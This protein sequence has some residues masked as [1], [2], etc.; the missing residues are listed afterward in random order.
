MTTPKLLVPDVSEWQ[1]TIDWSALV[2]GG[3]PAA[4]IRVYSGSRADTQFARN[5][6]EAHA[7]GIKALGLY[8][9][10]LPGDIEEQAAA[11]VSLVGTLRPGEWPIVDYEAA[12]LTPEE[13]L[14][15]IAHVSKAL[16]GSVPWLYASEYVFRSEHL[17]QV[18]PSTRTW[19]AAWGPT[20][21]SEAHE[22][23]QY[24][25]H[26]SGVPGI[27]GSV[28]CSTF[29][30]NVDQLVAA[31]SPKAPAP[32]PGPTSHPRFP[33]PAG[34]KP[35]GTSPS[36]R[37]LQQALKRTEWMDEN[38]PESDHYGPLTEKGV[39]GFNRKHGLNSSGKSWDP[40]IG[41]QGWA[42]LMTL[43]YGRD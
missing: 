4:I 43:A 9:Y 21:P 23:W 16:H 37:P 24:T 35:G 38:V 27:H 17:D 34:I 5:R 12:K 22:L 33:F 10:L 28:D 25:N 32:T 31:V 6:A 29:H 36:A 15:W 18:V 7:H 41:P 19:I 26:M 39:G 11:F 42:L 14:E 13:A 2:A 20:E 30:G 40:S 1:N 8:A 3:F